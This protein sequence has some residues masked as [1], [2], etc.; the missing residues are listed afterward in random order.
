MDIE[1]FANEGEKARQRGKNEKIDTVT[2]KAFNRFLLCF[3]RVQNVLYTRIGLD[4]L[5]MLQPRAL[6]L[7]KEYLA[8]SADMSTTA[9]KDEHA[10]KLVYLAQILIFMAHATIHEFCQRKNFADYEDPLSLAYKDESV[11]GGLT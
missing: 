5:R 10:K 6:A 7:F 4:E 3:F 11:K 9:H 8:F 2:E 1:A